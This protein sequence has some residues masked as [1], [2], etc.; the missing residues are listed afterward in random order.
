[1]DKVEARAVL[2]RELESYRSRAYTDLVGLIGNEVNTEVR[3]ESG[4]VYQVEIQALWESGKPGDLR[5]C[6]SIDDG[7]WRAFLPLTDDFILAPDGS[8]LGE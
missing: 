6:G 8:F 2:A 4:V 1:V 7:G 3:G 5:V